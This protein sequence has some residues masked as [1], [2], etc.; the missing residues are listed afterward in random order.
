MVSSTCVRFLVEVRVEAVGVH[1]DLPIRTMASPSI[2]EID[3]RYLHFHV[4][5]PTGRHCSFVYKTFILVFQQ[6]KIISHYELITWLFIPWKQL[7]LNPR[8]TKRVQ[9]SIDIELS[10]I[11]ASI[12]KFHEI[13]WLMIFGFGWFTVLLLPC[14]RRWRSI[15]KIVFNVTWI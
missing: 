2:R 6:N 12:K 5:S 4:W 7:V 14:S 8:S 11:N 1:H 9:R 13:R 3:Y 15:E 10:K